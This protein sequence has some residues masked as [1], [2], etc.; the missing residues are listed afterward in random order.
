MGT[1]NYRVMRRKKDLGHTESQ[2]FYEVFEVYYDDARRI[3]GHTVRS[4][5]PM[6]DTEDEIREDMAQYQAALTKPILEYDE[7]TG[8][9]KEIEWGT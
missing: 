3:N 9:Y 7:A 8:V 4:V 1:W 2:Y 6:G 5:M